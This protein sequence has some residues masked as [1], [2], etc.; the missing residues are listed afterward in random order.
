M[1]SKYNSDLKEG[2]HAKHSFCMDSF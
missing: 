2:I 1:I